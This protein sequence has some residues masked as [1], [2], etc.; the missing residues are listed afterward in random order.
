VVGRKDF[1]IWA[2]AFELYLS[3]ASLR[4]FIGLH[5]PQT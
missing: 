2:L 1:V 3:F 5:G 4:H